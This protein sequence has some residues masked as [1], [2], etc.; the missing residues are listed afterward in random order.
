MSLQQFR[1]TVPVTRTVRGLSAPLRRTASIAHRHQ[2]AGKTLRIVKRILSFQPLCEQ[3]VVPCFRGIHISDDPVLDPDVIPALVKF[4]SGADHISVP[5]STEGKVLADI[6]VRKHLRNQACG[7]GRKDHRLIVIEEYS[8][9]MHVNPG[10]Q[11][12]KVIR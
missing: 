9:R 1:Q 4:S 5:R 7:S 10:S 2:A 12:T 6:N 11:I 3:F 8:K